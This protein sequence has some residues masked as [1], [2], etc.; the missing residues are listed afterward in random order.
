MK[1]L[2]IR[3][4]TGFI[5][6]SVLLGSVLIGSWSFFI[7]YL[8]LCGLALHEYIVLS[9][10]DGSQPAVI[11]A[12]LLG[13][14]PLANS[15]L[16]HQFNLSG[17]LYP[18]VIVLLL[19]LFITELARKSKNPFRN[20]AWSSLGLFYIGIPFGLLSELAFS[21]YQDGYSY[22]LLIFLLLVIWT[23]DTGAYLTGALIGKTPFFKRISPKKTMEGF[24]GGVVFASI[25][26]FLLTKILHLA[27]AHH[28][29]ILGFAIMIFGTLGDLFE[30]MWKRS[31]GVKD[32]GHSLPGHGGWLDRLDSLLLA[33]PAVYLCLEL[34]C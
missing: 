13:L 7:V 4:I 8:I 22:E 18:G 31:M 17:T 1:E 32:S 34:L 14:W 3:T 5:Y 27:P 9:R 19:L 26:I 11:P 28:L 20:I 10:R 15:L 30:S 12:M 21:S 23:F 25:A 2:S 6:A 16:V 29:W 24:L 33:V